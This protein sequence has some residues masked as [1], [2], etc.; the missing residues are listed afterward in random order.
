VFM[1][2]THNL[3]QL[4]IGDIR[5]ARRIALF[6]E[7]FAE[8]ST[9]TFLTGECA[10][11]DKPCRDERIGFADLIRQISYYTEQDIQALAVTANSAM[12][13]HTTAQGFADIMCHGQPR[14]RPYIIGAAI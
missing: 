13:G 4:I 14:L 1:G 12:L 10:R 5:G 7:I 2:Y 3:N 8:M 9:A 6:C 11:Y